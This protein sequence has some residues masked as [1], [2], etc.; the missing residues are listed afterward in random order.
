M[1]KLL[2]IIFVIFAWNKLTAFWL[3][4]LNLNEVV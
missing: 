4:L 1:Y 2:G 3:F